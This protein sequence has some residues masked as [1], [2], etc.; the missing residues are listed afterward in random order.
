MKSKGKFIGSSNKEN[1]RPL[2]KEI[3]SVCAGGNSAKGGSKEYILELLLINNVI[4]F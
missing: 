3:S 4:L 2:G 1:D